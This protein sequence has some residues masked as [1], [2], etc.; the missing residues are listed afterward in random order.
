M[1]SLLA[2]IVGGLTGILPGILDFFN[3]KMQ[4]EYDYE[5][6]K[7]NMDI[8]KFRAE[9]EMDIINAQAD[10]FE[11]ESLRR[12]DSS[13]DSEGFI[14]ALRASVRPIITY[15]FFFLFIFVKIMT[16]YTFIN[17]GTSGDW[18][19]DSLAWAEIYPL[20]WDN[21]TQAIFGAV[22][23]FWFGSRVMEKLSKNHRQGYYCFAKSRLS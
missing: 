12:H 22:I 10:A 1:L 16:V 2:T 17:S 8:I 18:L 5:R 15:L 20:I 11:G 4:L 7:L 9:M 23:G 19:G 21:E 3:R 13:I 14:G 6:A